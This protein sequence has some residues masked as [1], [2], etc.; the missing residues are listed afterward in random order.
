MKLGYIPALDGVRG[1]CI[2]AVVLHH[3]DLPWFH[4]GFL[5]V[6]VFFVLSGFLIT[7]LL[8]Q[9]WQTKG[10]ID[11]R[12]FYYRRVLRLMPALLAVILASAFLMLLFGSAHEQADT[13]RGIWSSLLYV[14][15]WAL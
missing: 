15:N 14:S 1:I 5:G 12:R 8:V 10:S 13:W 9:E 3:L 6:D 7:T 4:V 11:L 2:L